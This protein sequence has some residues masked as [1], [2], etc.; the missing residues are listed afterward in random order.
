MKTPELLL[1]LGVAIAIVGTIISVLVIL[2]HKYCYKCDNG[3]CVPG[4]G[5]FAKDKCGTCPPACNST[6][7]CNSHGTCNADGTCLCN[8]GYEGPA[9][10]A[11]VLTYGCDNGKCVSGKGQF[12]KDGCGTCPPACNSTTTCNSHGTCNPDGTCLCNT[13]Y[14][15]P[16]CAASVPV[17]G[18][19]KWDCNGNGDG[20]C[21]KS[22]AG[23]VSQRACETSCLVQPTSWDSLFR[24][25]TESK[26]AFSSRLLQSQNATGTQCTAS[27]I[28]T[29]DGFFSALSTMVRTGVNKQ[30][31]YG[32]DTSEHGLLYG[33]V[34]IAAFMSQ[35]MQ[36]TI[37]YDACD[38]NNW[39]SSGNGAPN[40]GV[41]GYDP[42]SK[43]FVDYPITAA[44]GQ[45]GQ[46]YQDYVC[47]ES[48]KH[49]A[50]VVDPLMKTKAFTHAA[51]YG[52]PPPLFCAPQTMTGPNLGYWDPRGG[53]CN[54]IENAPTSDI[55]DI[56]DYIEYM[57]N[58]STCGLYAG[59][60]A[61]VP[62]T[63]RPIQNM[64]PNEAAGG[65]SYTKPRT[66]VEGCCW[67]GRGVIQTS[68]PCNIGK[69]NYFMG[70]GPAA[71]GDNT[72]LF[73]GIDFCQTPEVI[74]DPSSPPSIK[75]I[76]GMFYW[77][78]AVQSYDQG[79]WNYLTELKRFV[80]GAGNLNKGVTD[81]G[82]LSF[83]NGV[84]GIVNRGCH[85]P[86]CGTGDLLKGE[87]RAINFCN[88]LSVLGVRT[89][90]CDEKKDKQPC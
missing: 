82:F 10:A 39:S 89:N 32:G 23:V 28:Y 34:N 47:P 13:G 85:N 8:T 22:D 63:T 33:L 88:A 58:G 80:D 77:I 60:R 49:M 27:K 62:V 86:P 51:W 53:D 65:T 44:C 6:T 52:N 61:G 2:T 38:E 14:E 59:Q 66:D 35:C 40:Q 36:E 37:L 90:L 5:Q 4:K 12:A 29:F 79:G 19:D 30:H 73:P 76:A 56:D 41:Q 26:S 43:Q 45:S 69:L 54:G 57:K 84:S 87:E 3:K 24:R 75:W 70:T 55:T 21:V 81:T 16:A 64:G 15:G 17:S 11:S 72:A 83:I 67:W 1:T 7:T 74:C 9:C 18:G 25:L 31:F 50:C 20:T 78:N 68:G 42:V 48:E 46:S 71:R